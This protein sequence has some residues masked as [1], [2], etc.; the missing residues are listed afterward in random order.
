MASLPLQNAPLAQVLGPTG[1]GQPFWGLND[2]GVSSN[3]APLFATDPYDTFWLGTRQLP[4]ECSLMVGDVAQLELNIKKGKG[5]DGARIT[6]TGMKAGKFQ[7][8]C[9]IVTPE[10]WAEI[11]DV[12]DVYWR[13][14]GKTSNLS[15][16]AISVFHP[17]LASVDVY[18][19]VIDGWSPP[20][21][22]KVE[23]AKNVVISF[24]W[25]IYVPKKKNVTKSSA[26]PAEDAR[27]PASAKLQNETPPAPSSD[28][29]NASTGGPPQNSTIGA[30]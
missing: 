25:S 16:V 3:E 19:A 4:G 18:S 22:G 26:A 10:Q 23:G 9:Q 29:A 8:S 12:R 15:Q 20:Q 6:V 11:Q 5:L 2:A 13:S 17:A 1:G 28:P 30:S 14:P 24:V 7:L 27:K 21:D